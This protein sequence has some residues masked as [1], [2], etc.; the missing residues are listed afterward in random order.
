[1]AD[2]IVYGL[3]RFAEVFALY[4][5]Q[6]VII[7]GAACRAELMESP[8]KPRRT[9]DIDM[10]LVLE[11]LD[12]DFISTFWSFIKDGQYKCG[13]R[14]SD[15]GVKYVLYS[16]EEG[17]E[18]FP[19]KVELLSRPVDGLGTPEEHHI[20]RI[21]LGEE[22][23]Y[24]SAIILEPDYYNYLISNTDPVKGL[25]FASPSALV[26]LKTLAYMNLHDDKQKGIHVNEKDYKKHRRDVIMA[27]ASLKVGDEFVVPATIRKKISEFIETINSEPGVRQ[28]LMGSCEI[29]EDETLDGYIELLDASFI[30]E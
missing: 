22:T 13:T 27:A 16:F 26:C 23:S 21:D 18:G 10:V 4:K 15:E 30:E 2:G 11:H 9:E 5:E 1:M 3:E 25:R 8:I 24:I 6:F 20:E 19:L 14:K 12:K 28:S 29:K 17:R 7:G